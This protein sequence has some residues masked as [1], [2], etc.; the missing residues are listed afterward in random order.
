MKRRIQEL[1]VAQF[2]LLKLIIAAL[3]LFPNLLGNYINL[4]ESPLDTTRYLTAL[5]L[6]ID[7]ALLR[8]LFAEELIARK[9]RSSSMRLSNWNAPN[10][11]L[12]AVASVPALFVG[13]VLFG[14]PIFDSWL[15]TLHL[16]MLLS[17]LGFVPFCLIHGQP[18]EELLKFLQAME[19]DMSVEKLCF[20]PGLMAVVGAWCGSVVIPLDWDRPWQKWPIPCCYA[21]FVG[22]TLGHVGWLAALWWKSCTKAAYAR[23]N[24]K[25]DR[26][27]D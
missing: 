6:L 27:A 17:V 14:A 21:A 22:Y 13:I 2:C 20:V 3:P 9:A 1:W 12:F 16:A 11:G 24:S 19:S 5:I 18:V 26:F 8:Y 4:V 7:V 23:S 15:E 25:T 10:A